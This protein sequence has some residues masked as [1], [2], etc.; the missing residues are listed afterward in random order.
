[1]LEEAGEDVGC[2]TEIV[3]ITRLEVE[4]IGM[5]DHSGATPMT[6]RKDALAAAA[7][8]VLAFE[9]RA[10]E[11]TRGA[12][13]ATVGKLDVSPNASNAVPG[14]VTFILEIRAGQQAI[15][16]DYLDWAEQ[17]IGKICKQRSLKSNMKVI[18]TSN[19][20]VMA[21]KVQSAI[22]DAAQ[23]NGLKARSMPSGAGHDAAYMARIAPTGMV[24][25]PCAE[26]RSHCPEEY[27]TPEQLAKGAQILLDAVLRLDADL[28]SQI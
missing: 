25:I 19:P 6:L 21:N 1:V 9:A 13:V 15:L 7:Q 17:E 11:E 22:L 14:K 20:V 10:N 23:A 5:A 2:V 26:G 24:F 8:L 4:I 18:G 16:D 3:G 27:T 12:M 28:T